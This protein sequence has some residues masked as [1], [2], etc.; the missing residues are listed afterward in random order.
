[1]LT[2]DLID[3][4]G[5][6]SRRDIAKYTR[7]HIN[8]FYINWQETTSPFLR[9]PL[10]GGIINNACLGS[11]INEYL[12]LYSHKEYRLNSNTQGGDKCLTLTAQFDISRI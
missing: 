7:Y 12:T 9:L 1:M 10:Q 4:T 8:E 3:T 5:L 2:K 11:A 6:Q